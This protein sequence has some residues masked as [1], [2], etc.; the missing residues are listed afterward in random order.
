[1]NKIYLNQYLSI[2]LSVVFLVL[3][4]NNA[5]LTYL[6]FNLT[7]QSPEVFSDT[8]FQ[9]KFFETVFLAIIHL[10]AA[11]YLALMSIV[12]FPVVE[13]GKESKSKKDSD[14]SQE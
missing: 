11:L 5:Y 4:S 10:S 1:M 3:F 9:I 12:K 6:L 2:V 8:G 14:D 7:S 13:Y